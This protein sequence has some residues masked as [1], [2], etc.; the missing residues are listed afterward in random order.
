MIQEPHYAIKIIQEHRALP[1][2]RESGSKVIFRIQ[3]GHH[4]HYFR[5]SSTAKEVEPVDEVYAEIHLKDAVNFG[6]EDSRLVGRVVVIVPAKASLLD[7]LDAFRKAGYLVDQIE[8][9]MRRRQQTSYLVSVN[10]QLYWPLTRTLRKI[11]DD[12]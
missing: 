8:K 3:E 2:R 10:K 6:Y 1:I 7:K 11:V 12:V 5:Y 9:D 4:R